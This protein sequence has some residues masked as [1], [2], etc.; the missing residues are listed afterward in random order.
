MELIHM[1]IY[2][3]IIYRLRAREIERS[4]SRGIDISRTL[5][6]KYRLKAL[7]EEYLDMPKNS[8]DGRN[9]YPHQAK[10]AVLYVLLIDNLLRCYRIFVP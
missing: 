2:N 4:I 6:C 5:V 3:E 1:N 7:L 8:S 9:L 10:I